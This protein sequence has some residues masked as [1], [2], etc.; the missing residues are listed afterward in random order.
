VLETAVRHVRH[1]ETVVAAWMRSAPGTYTYLSI[2][3]VTS[4]SLRGA[5][6]RLADRLIQSQSTNLHNLQIRPLQV[7]VA[8]AF[9]TS[10]S[11]IPWQLL[12]RFTVIMAPVERR[13]GTRR[14]VTVFAAGHV[15]ATL[16]VVAGIDIGIQHGLLD[17]KLAHVSDVGVSYGLYAVAG[18]LTWLLVPHRW[19]AVWVL[20]VLASISVAVIGGITF[21]DVGHYLSLLIGLST[22]PLV[23][24]W[25]R[26]PVPRAALGGQPIHVDWEKAQQRAHRLRRRLGGTSEIADHEVEAVPEP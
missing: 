7:L 16:L 18:G 13:L 23:A 15:I 19:R 26:A 1:A 17:F 11:A 21:T 25:Q 22:A 10:G 24:H 14:T 2:I 4:W 5:D 3:L 20:A 6:P 12:L 9:W 8:S